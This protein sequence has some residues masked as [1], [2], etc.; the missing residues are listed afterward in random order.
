MIDY[1]DR[2]KDLV[3]D[4]EEKTLINLGGDD[5]PL[6]RHLM[7]GE[8]QPGFIFSDGMLRKWYWDGIRTVDGVKHVYFSKLRLTSFSRISTTH[9]KK[10]LSLLIDLAAALLQAP[11][12][13]ADLQVGIIQMY[14]IFIVDDDK[15]LLLPPDLADVFN[16]YMADS[17]RYIECS[18]YA[19]GGTEEGFA[20][21]RQ[22]G[23]L[24]YEALTGISPYEDRNIRDHQYKELPLS[25]FKDEL[26]PSLDEKTIGFINFILHARTTEQRDIMGNRRPEE[27]LEWFVE[28]AR[29]CTW[30]VD[31]LT[32]EERKAAVDRVF[33]SGEVERFMTR[34]IE[35]A[36]RHNFW[37]LWGTVI[38]STIIAIILFFAFF[39]SMLKNYLAPPTVKGMDQVGVITSFYDAQNSLDAERLTEALKGCKAP[40][41]TEVINL[42]VNT[43]T[44]N[45][46]ENI[47]V[48]IRAD[49]WVEAG[50]PAIEKGKFIYGVS[51]LKIT[52]LEE[53][54]YRAE[55]LFYTPFPYDEDTKSEA[56]LDE[57]GIPVYAQAFCY[58]MGQTFHL[59]YN[60]RGWY[61]IV[62]ITEDDY[63]YVGTETVDVK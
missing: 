40:Q 60:K 38:T 35:G 12:G 22:F 58:R 36:K 28:H 20:L 46:Y 17:E 10:A 1:T 50:K 44:R 6:P 34:T 39:F 63:E 29:E 53:N 33:A 8:K 59:R 52:Q 25:I 42:F 56:Y 37:R 18:A 57:K 9:R 47:D 54:V 11:K 61:N 14:R 55:Y 2:I 26:F 13:F 48:V 23:A 45:A 7:S 31:N 51:D 5:F 41:E 49:R 4:G 15:L 16:I 21:V 19:K 62:A 43:R 27:N 30:D 24:L 32:E 3:I